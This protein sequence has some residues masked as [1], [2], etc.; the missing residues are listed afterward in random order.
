MHTSISEMAEFRVQD[1]LTSLF[2]L[3]ITPISC[4]LINA[5]FTAFTHF[6]KIYIKLSI[7]LYKSKE[8]KSKLHHFP[9]DV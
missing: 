1:Q 7:S 2:A 3:Y 6:Y 8:I 5:S 4:I 9:Y